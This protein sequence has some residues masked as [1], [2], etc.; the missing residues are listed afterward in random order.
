MKFRFLLPAIYLLIVVVLILGLV[1]GAGHQPRALDFLLYVITPPCYLLELLLP[2]FG[3]RSVLINA[4][5]C[6]ATGIVMYTLLGILI[7]IGLSKYRIRRNRP[8]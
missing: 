2:H 4:F 5:L 3:T 7:D 8:K 1:M 6:L